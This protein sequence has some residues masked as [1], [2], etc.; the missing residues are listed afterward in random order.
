M[1]CSLLLHSSLASLP[2]Q[3]GRRQ[4]GKYTLGATFVIISEIFLIARH[5]SFGHVTIARHNIKHVLWRATAAR[6][7][8]YS[9]PGLRCVHLFP[10]KEDC[11]SFS[12]GESNMYTSG[13]ILNWQSMLTEINETGAIAKIRIWVESDTDKH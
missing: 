13:S 11:S 6:V 10:Q 3:W 4:S 8:F 12:W 7:A 9:R 1:R 2:C 5:K